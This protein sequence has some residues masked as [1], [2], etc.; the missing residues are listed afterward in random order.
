MD[1]KAKA[2]PR[3]RL[4]AAA[5][6]LFDRKGFHST[7]I[8][9]LAETAKI[10]VGQMYRLFPGKDDLIVAIVAENTDARIV[11]MERVF[12]SMRDG[13]STAF[14]AIKAIARLSIDYE[15]ALSFEML[16]EAH[17]NPRVAERLTEL[18]TRY[19]ARIRELAMLARPDV[20]APE[21]DAYADILMACFFGLGHRTLIA[22]STD[23]ERASHQTACLLARALAIPSH[24]APQA[25]DAASP[26]RSTAARKGRKRNP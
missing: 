6:E 16:A 3:E 7:S 20:L 13:R 5:R 12:E 14:E 1:A 11:E 9:D 15:S 17:R 21:L 22:P 10:S 2:T 19:R 8:S 23:I 4:I 18:A 25:T 26:A 24:L